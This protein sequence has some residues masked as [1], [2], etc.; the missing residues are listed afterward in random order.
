M[1]ILITGI[2]C[3]GKSSLREK[4]ASDYPDQ[5][6]S[7]DM[8]YDREIPRVRNKIVVVESVHGLEEN[9]QRYDKILYLQSPHNHI[10]V[11]LRRA[12]TWFAAGIVDFSEP[13]GK[14]K[15]Y[16]IY[17]IPIILKILARNIFLKNRWIDNDLNLIQNKFRDRTQIASSIGE[18]YKIIKS[19]INLYIKAEKP[20]RS[21]LFEDSI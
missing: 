18:G 1:N 12:W 9:P 16:S 8:D 14:M 21:S 7:V 5:V 13:K 3:I 2:G 15:R 19:W 6:I 20:A 10:A 17:N 4:I 11:W